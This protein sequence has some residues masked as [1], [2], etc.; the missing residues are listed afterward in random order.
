[1]DMPSP[2][3]DDPIEW[4]DSWFAE[5]RQT[6]MTD[7]N[8]MCLSTVDAAGLPSSRIVLLKDYDRDGF[9]FYTNLKSMK[10][11]QLEATQ[12]AALNFFWRDIGRQVR[13]EG[14]TEQVEDHVADEYFATRDRGSQ[15]GAWASRQSRPLESREELIDRV[16][17]LEVEFQ[18]KEVP[19]PPHWSGVRVRPVRIEFWQ[20][21]DY[22]LHNRF[23]FIRDALDG[24]WNPT[25]LYP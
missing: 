22:R 5:A 17:E 18:G 4:F 25:R 10:G 23:V 19:R 1:M 11:Q 7:P 3:Y 21:G 14:Q 15:I 24:D 13:I 8:A 16:E 2:P 9:V 12:V 20:A 6:G